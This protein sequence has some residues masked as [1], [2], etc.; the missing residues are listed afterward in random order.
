MVAKAIRY[1][2]VPAYCP[3]EFG[4][5]DREYNGVLV[6]V[7]NVMAMDSIPIIVEL[8]DDDTGVELAIDIPDMAL[9]GVA[10]IDIVMPDIDALSILIL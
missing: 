4:V 1:M 3:V 10:D 6:E 7:K 5:Q 9:V 8:D 2:H